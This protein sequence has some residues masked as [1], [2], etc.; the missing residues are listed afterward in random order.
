MV[1][2]KYK[3][4][5]IIPAYNVEQYLERCIESCEKQDISC[6]NYEI[7]IV[8]DGSTD[9]T[10]SIANRL[11]IKYENIK[12]F[13]QENQGQSIA[14]NLGL[15][16]SSGKYIWFIDSDDYIKEN[17]LRQS[18]QTLE[19]NHLEILSFR[20]EVF[21]NNGR[22]F[23][24]KLEDFEINKVYDGEYLIM[25]NVIVGSVCSRIFLKS[26]L[27]KYRLVFFPKILHQDSEFTLRCFSL[28]KRM[29]FLDEVF[30]FYEFNENSSTREKSYEKQKKSHLSLAQISA[31]IRDFANGN[32]VISEK[33]K[34]YLLRRAN[35]MIISQLLTYILHSNPY[36]KQLINDYLELSKSLNIYPIKG[37]SVRFYSNI[38]IPILNLES[39]YL[40]LT[41]IKK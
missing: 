12:I 24:S 4:S 23:I 2:Y 17:C 15:R 25:N 13:S 9:S 41:R 38:L 8:D 39:I 14:R 7:L 26:F 35:S 11:S 6:R 21:R 10:L 3:L 22:S 28:V 29:L 18:L 40:Y 37:R 16:K 20:M 27:D 31:N 19:E 5:I 36:K 1:D 34:R 32:N 30:Y 33:L